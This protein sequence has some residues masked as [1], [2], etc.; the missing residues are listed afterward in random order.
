M[1][2]LKL[3]VSEIFLQYCLCISGYEPEIL[4]II[5]RVRWLKN[6]NYINNK[7]V[8]V[9]MDHS[10]SGGDNQYYEL[11]LLKKVFFFHEIKIY[12]A[13]LLLL[14][15]NSFHSFVFTHY[16]LKLFDAFHTEPFIISLSYLVSNPTQRRG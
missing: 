11:I 15:K 9:V 7:I 2:I 16:F 4:V 1:H 10:S 14:L 8:V 3:S 5:V 12:L 13:E 6:N